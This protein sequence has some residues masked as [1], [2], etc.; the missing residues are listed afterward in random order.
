MKDWRELATWWEEK[1]GDTGDFWHRSFLDPALFAQIGDVAEQRVLDMACGNGHN[2]RRLARMGATV[3]GIDFSA[4]LIAHNREREATDPLGITYHT[5]DAAQLEMLPDAAFDLVICQM[6]LM[7]IPDAAA[8][9]GEAARVLRERGRFVALLAHPCFDVPEASGWVV[10]RM[11]PETHVW[12]KVSRYREPFVGKIAWRSG[13]QFMYTAT[14]HRPLSW[15]VQALRAAGMALTA[16][17][18]PQP[19]ETLSNVAPDYRWMRDMPLLCLIEARKL[20]IS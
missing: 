14:Y 15:Y 18:E 10:E 7:D 3:V 6:A 1:Q 4:T 17:V 20:D 2:A 11:W 12:R 8:A 5:A 16:F 13:D 9:I 19:D